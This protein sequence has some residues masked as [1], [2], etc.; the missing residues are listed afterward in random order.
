MQENLVIVESPAK[1]KTIEKLLGKDY[2]V[3]S[4]YGHIRDLVKKGLGVDVN[5]NFKPEYVISPDKKKLVEELKKL[6][7]QAK[8]VWLA[9]DEDREG[10]AIA[11]HLQNVLKL[12]DKNTKRITF[13]EITKNAISNAIENPRKIDINLVNAQQARRILDRLVGFEVSPILWKK[14]KSSLSA[15]RVQSVAVR[16]IV[17]REREIMEFKTESSYKVSAIFVS[18][19]KNEKFQLKATLLSDFKTEKE[20]EDFLEKCKNS[21]FTVE[22]VDK[23]P[24][25]KSPAAP[26]TTST[27]QQEASR[28]FRFSVAQTMNIAQR[29]YE[30]GLITYMRTDSTNLS[31]LALGAAKNT[32]ENLFGAKYVKT[33]QYKTK[34][35]SAQEAHEAIRPTYLQNTEVEGA[36]Q[37]KKLY[38]LIWKR[39]IASQMADAELEKT[40][41][42]INISN[43]TKK[44]QATGEIII[45]DG[46]LKVYMESS[47]DDNENAETTGLLPALVAGQTVARK[48]I[49]ATQRFSQHPPR[50]TEASLVKKLEELGIGRPS[51][52]APTISTIIAREYVQKEDRAGFER[53]YTKITLKTNDIVTDK[54]KEVVGTEKSKFFP[55]DIGI[56]VTDFLIENFSN[57]LDFSFTAKIEEYFDEIAEGKLDWV[58]MLHKFYKPFH[59][60]VDNSLETAQLANAERILGIDPKS[61]KQVSARIARFGPIAQLGTNDDPEKKFSSLK[62]EQLIET[63]TLDEALKLFDLP[64]TIGEYEGKEIVAST[65]RFGPYVRHDS[66]FISMKKNIDDPYT[67]TEKRAIELI[68]EK[69]KKDS[70]R[71]IAKFGDIE[72]LNGFYGPYIA[73]DGK[74]YKIPKG[75][76]PKTLTHQDCIALIDEQKSKEP[77]TKTRTKTKAK[78]TTKKKQ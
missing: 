71:N 25:K 2:F 54:L 77:K 45:F 31:T 53:N 23:K 9:S 19:D 68:E 15:G 74:N 30:R 12:D 24:T 32:I 33:R 34:S 50:Y 58:V 27:L 38:D 67:I 39:T 6:S 66:K 57:I 14:V 76:D 49:T 65:G 43:E 16:L 22:S 20:A 44:F 3:T 60:K 28:K 36:P 18:T 62:K 72:V 29:L 4:S 69:R 21:I 8:T 7:K 42:N 37:E 47:D 40:T 41:I 56:V 46:F 64:R 48:E 73:Y 70:E 51:T 52:Y 1:A 11:W 59:Q 26:F 35:K 63:L 75:Q 17:E 55:S 10:E 61:G 5:D 13:N 78:T